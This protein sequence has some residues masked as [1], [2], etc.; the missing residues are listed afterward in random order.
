LSIE[1]SLPLR[2]SRVAANG[3][4]RPLRGNNLVTAQYTGAGGD[5]QRALKYISIV[6]KT[7]RT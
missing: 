3:A 4:R 1:K 6:Q 7:L 2:D 5:L